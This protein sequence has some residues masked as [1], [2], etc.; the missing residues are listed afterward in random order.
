VGR[1]VSSTHD[2]VPGRAPVAQKNGAK[3][4]LVPTDLFHTRRVKWLFG[5]TL[6]PLNTEVRVRAIPQRKYSTTNWWQ[7]E[8]GLVGFQNEVLK[9][10]LYRWKY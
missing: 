1:D 7:H 10:A 9:F 2:E 5:R 8:D 3:Q 6:A 4:I